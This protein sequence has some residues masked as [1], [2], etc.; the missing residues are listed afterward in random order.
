VLNKGFD[1]KELLEK[2]ISASPSQNLGRLACTLTCMSTG[3]LR[4][5]SRTLPKSFATISAIEA[6][7]DA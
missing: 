2:T 5:A 1:L 6:V 3:M 7:K 4:L